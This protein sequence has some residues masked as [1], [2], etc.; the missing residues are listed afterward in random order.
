VDEG[1]QI[2]A[3]YGARK[4]HLGGVARTVYIVDKRG[5][6]RYAQQGKPPDAE[7]LEVLRGLRE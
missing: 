3:K 7:L 2:T 4:T 5:A 6:I 1:G